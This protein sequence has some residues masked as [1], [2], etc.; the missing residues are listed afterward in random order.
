MLEYWNSG[1]ELGKYLFKLDWNPQPHYSIISLF[2]YSTVIE[3]S[4][5][6]GKH[7]LNH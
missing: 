7:R 6:L 4:Q 3:R 5:P 2:H 1:S